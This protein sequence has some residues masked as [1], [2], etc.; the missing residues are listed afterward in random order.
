MKTKYLSLFFCLFFLSAASGQISPES[1]TIIDDLPDPSPKYFSPQRLGKAGSCGVDTL[2]YPYY[3]SSAFYAVTL[4]TAS[5]GSAFSQYYPAPQQPVTV[6][7]FDFFAYQSTGT[8]ATVTITCNLYLSTADSMPLGSPARS[9]TIQIDSTFG[10][11]L[12][13]VLR[14]HISFPNPITVN[15]P[16]IITLETSSSTN[17]SVICNNYVNGDGDAEYLSGVKINGSWQ[18]GYQVNVG[19]YPFNADFILMP[20]VSYDLVADFTF[21]GCNQGNTSF[22]FT[23][24]SS[25][26]LRNT[27]YN[28]YAYYGIPQFGMQWDFGDTTGKIY[29]IDAT[30]LYQK[31]LPYTVTLRDTM[32]GWTVGCVDYAYKVVPYRPIPPRASNDGPHCSGDTL[33]IF[34]DTVPGVSYSWKGPNAFSSTDQNLVFPQS[35]TSMNGKYYLSVSFMTC[36]SVD[37]VTEVLIRQ[38]PQKPTAVNDGPKCVGDS[39]VFEASS[40]SPGISY[41]WWGPNGFTDNSDR[42]VFYSL[43]TNDVGTYSVFVYDTYCVSDTDSTVLYTYPPP[44]IPVL[45]TMSNDSICQ[46]DTV[47]LEGTSVTGATFDWLGPEGFQSQ[48][49]N[50]VIPATDTMQTGWYSSRV[51]IGSCISDRDSIFV[52]VLRMPVT[53]AITGS[54]TSTEFLVKTY[55]APKDYR[56]GLIWTCIGGTILSMDSL[57]GDIT[58]EWGPEG[59]GK[60]IVNTF[61]PGGCEGF[62]ERLDVEVLPTPPPPVDPSGIAMQTHSGLKVYPN[63]TR[64]HLVLN[65]PEELEVSGYELRNL[66]GQ[67]LEQ[68]DC[69]SCK[70]IRFRHAA[71]GTYYLILNSRQGPMAVLIRLED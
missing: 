40:P 57:T 26:L 48:V 15:A 66:Q 12:L 56:D 27:F 30:H 58:V 8:S 62:S 24:T 61:T 43:D 64:G 60:L 65:Y 22:N 9:T 25:P 18:R 33:R 69:A 28:R 54:D 41:R 50:P 39:V 6:S 5:S 34:A 10:G 51:I 44:Q 63:P 14:K 21:S 70:E 2:Y 3:K 4:N 11:G 71:A 17:V 35:D 55:S 29:A 45:S 16:Y 68:S 49:A 59:D 19:S 20:N 53:S 38:T 52:T 7:G 31:R 23:N 47:F 37:S 13:S 32:Y 36:K 42:F 46:G 1:A 67:V